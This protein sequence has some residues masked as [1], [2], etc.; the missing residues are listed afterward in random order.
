MTNSLTNEQ[1]ESFHR[2]GY[3]VVSSF[4][5]RDTEI[6]P[7]Q[8]AIHG[9]IGMIIRRH[10]LAIRQ[11]PFRPE[12]FDSG[13]NELIAIDRSYGGEVYDA[14]KLIPAFVRLAASKRNEDAVCLLRQTKHPGFINRGYGMRIDFPQEEHLRAHWH[15]E[16]LFQLRSVDGLIFWSPL[17]TMTKELGPVIIGRDSHRQGIFPVAKNGSARG[18]YSWRL[19]NEMVLASQY[20]HVAPLTYPGDVLIMDFLA[21]HC[22]GNNTANRARWSMQMRFFNFEESTG[23]R[24]GWPGSVTDGVGFEKYHPECLAST[25]EAA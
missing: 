2:N 17:L 4:Y 16:Y 11:A 25:E 3:V 24:H 23:F 21:L 6:E 10:G 15:Q 20:E 13:L 7:I 8:R 22:S 18:A 1:V 9:I 5:D 19:K 14:V 12:T